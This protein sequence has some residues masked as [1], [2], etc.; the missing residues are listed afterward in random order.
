MKGLFNHRAGGR[1][2]KNVSLYR[3]EI[4]VHPHIA[5]PATLEAC[6]SATNVKSKE[7]TLLTHVPVTAAIRTRAVAPSMYESWLQCSQCCLC[8]LCQT[9]YWTAFFVW[10]Q[11]Q[12]L[13][14]QRVWN[15]SATKP[16]IVLLDLIWCG[17]IIECAHQNGGSIW[18]ANY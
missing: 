15:H 5:L 2:D 11:S 4:S 13:F 16:I 14:C 3:Q 12:F 9:E 18:L 6:C 1:S 10:W 8:C 17:S 7:I